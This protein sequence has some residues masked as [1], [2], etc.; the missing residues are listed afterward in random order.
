MTDI[1]NHALLTSRQI[2]KLALFTALT[3]GWIVAAIMWLAIQ[4]FHP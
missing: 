3:G 1:S 2:W 4:V